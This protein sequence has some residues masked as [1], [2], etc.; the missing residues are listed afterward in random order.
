MVGSRAA[1]P[2]GSARPI[3]ALSEPI[4]WREDGGAVRG[5]DGSDAVEVDLLTGEVRRRSGVLPV[6]YDVDLHLESG[7]IKRGAEVLQWG[8]MEAS[9]ALRGHLLAGP[10]GVIWDLRAAEPLFTDPR[11]LLGVT[12][13]IPQGFATVHWETGRGHILS[14]HG[15]VLSEIALPLED[16]DVL[17]GSG[18]DQSLLSAAGRAWSVDGTEIA[19]TEAVPG[20]TTAEVA[21]RRYAWNESGQLAVSD[22][23]LSG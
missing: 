15:D 16:E 14:P 2:T 20:P 13:A 9:C 10:G 23:T 19:P 17:A 12:V 11:V 8:V 7:E 3:P 5:M 18:A 21:G 22:G 6:S 1:S 4:R